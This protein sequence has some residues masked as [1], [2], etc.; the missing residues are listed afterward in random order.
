MREVDKLE[1]PPIEIEMRTPSPDGATQ[2]K[3]K[4]VLTTIEWLKTARTW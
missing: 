3:P 2:M 4:K 1:A